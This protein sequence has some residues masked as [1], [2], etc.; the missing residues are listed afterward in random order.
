MVRQKTQKS[1]ELEALLAE[2][3]LGIQNKKYKSSYEAAKALGLSRNTVS[4]RVSQQ[5]PSR[6]EARQKQQLLSKNQER[7][8]LKWIK[9]LTNSGYAP[10]HRILREV[11][12]EVRSNKCRVFQPQQQ[13]IQQHI[14]QHLQQQ[15]QTQQLQPQ[16]PN[17]PLGQEWV[18]RFIQ[19]HPN[20]RVKLGR[21]VEAQRMNGVTKQVL[22]GWF[23]AYKSLITELK[24]ETY[25]TY[26]MDETG[27]SIRTMQSTRIIVDSTLRTRF[28]AHPGR[29]EW[30]SA[31]ECIC[32]DGTAID[33]LIIFKGQN[34]LQS[35]IPKEVIQKWHFSANTKGW[36]S[37]LHGLEWLKRVFKPSTRV[38]ATQNGRL[39]QRLLICDG[40]DSHISGSFISHY[41]Q[42]QI[43]LLI[44]PPHT[45]HVLQPLDI[46][47]FGPLKQHLTTAL[48]HLNEA[49]LLRIQKS[50]WMDAYITARAA[51]FSTSNINSA[52]RGSG[53]Q[54]FQPQTV[55]RA[56]TLP[57][58]DV[59]VE[60]PHT[61]TEHDIFEKVFLNSSPPDFQTLY[62]A[63]TVLS[64]IIS[65][66]VLNTPIKRYINKLVDKTERL[67]TRNTL[68]KR[69]YDNLRLI[70]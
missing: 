26:N 10:S 34:I 59:V 14:Q 21:R 36:T 41:I 20:L 60:R 31:V 57:T 29:Q 37:N 43:S 6:Q 55:I 30:V 18:P 7:T 46:S 38:K 56:A 3:I 54:P 42:N 64:S 51:A 68:Q 70:I 11:A 1:K 25:N 28:Q 32:I 49:Q 13:H 63:N 15:P 45:S 17:L 50:E 52:W 4:K 69:E 53:L 8:L 27:F 65:C 61:P 67:N 16:I 40:H 35:W 9:E 62:K 19:R 33:P 39:Q 12:D 22:K 24:I 2:A 58:T 44:I 47:I 23:D 48:L 66:S 5:R